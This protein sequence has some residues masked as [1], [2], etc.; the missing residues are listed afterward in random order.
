MPRTS[1]LEYFQ[2]D[3]RPSDEIAVVW[4]SGYRTVRWPYEELYRA[5]TTFAWELSARGIQKGDRVLLWAENSGL[6]VAAFLGC[7]FTGAVCVPM[8][9][10]ADKGFAERVAG[11]AGIRLAVLGKGLALSGSPSQTLQIEDFFESE[12][13]GRQE[14]FPSP[15]ITGSDLVQIVFTSGTTAE[16]RGVVLTHS[17]ILANIQPI[18][19]EFG[20]YRRYERFFHPLK[21]LDL[22]PLSHVFGQLL[23]IFIPQ[24]LGATV[25]FLDTLNPSEVVRAVKSQRVSVLVTVPRL[26]ESLQD[27][28]KRDLTARAR[29]EKFQRDFRASQGEHFLKRWWRFRAIRRRFG[30]KFL[31]I[32][33][34]GATLPSAVEEFWKR[35][36]YAVIQGY[37]LTETTALVSLNHPFRL[38]TGSIGKAMPGL[39]MK[40][41]RRRRNPGAR[42]EYRAELLAARRCCFRSGPRW[43]V[44]HRRSRRTR[45]GG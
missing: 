13:N 15:S 5:A 8:D 10:A 3:S 23:G 1:L 7:M 19:Q 12:K 24:I 27:Q 11:L 9:L 35:L 28:I 21:I 30:W 37:G 42:P 29:L 34:G 36:G 4:R 32:V 39:E 26:L 31:A 2:R 41:S 22:L 20:R 45:R 17:N 14:M 6:W 25:V 44:P 16:P 40:L 18:E 38:G 33:C 43:M